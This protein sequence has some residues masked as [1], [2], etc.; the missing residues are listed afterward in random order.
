MTQK[1]TGPSENPLA[2]VPLAPE[3]DT[4]AVEPQEVRDSVDRL[5]PEL[6]RR[7]RA[8]CPNLGDMDDLASQSDLAGVPLAPE[9]DTCAVEP[10]E[11][12]LH[13]QR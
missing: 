11:A 6:S 9:D 1:K 3:D 13:R 10:Q 2:G 12:M 7:L 4:C 8:E 5:V